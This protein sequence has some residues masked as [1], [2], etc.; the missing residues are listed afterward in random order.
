MK[1]L[2]LALAAFA[3]V[4]A[5]CS[6]TASTNTTATTTD[7][8]PSATTDTSAT[9]HPQTGTL[10][11]G[12]TGADVDAPGASAS[13]T[14]SATVKVNMVASNFAFTPSTITVKVG[15][16]V[17]ITFTDVAGF[18]GFVIDNVTSNAISS[19]TVVKF[20]APSAPGSYPYYCNV[21][22]HRAMGMQGTLIVQ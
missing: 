10:I 4:G 21:A 12:A 17:E 6:G 5:G 22:N 1:K 8:T 2:L 11:N 18:H 16:P 15:Q 9:A 3:L 7:T 19:G 14:A 13:A 20:N